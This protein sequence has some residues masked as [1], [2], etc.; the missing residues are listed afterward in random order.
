M[1]GWLI[2]FVNKGHYAQVCCSLKAVITARQTQ[3]WRYVSGTCAYIHYTHVQGRLELLQ[4][5]QEEIINE[6]PKYSQ[7]RFIYRKIYSYT[8]WVY[9]TEG[10]AV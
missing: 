10:L 2:Y 3:T 4:A 7:K 1:T 6:A 8:Q 5:P 9:I